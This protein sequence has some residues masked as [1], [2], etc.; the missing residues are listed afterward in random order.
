MLALLALALTATLLGERALR[1]HLLDKALQFV[2]RAFARP[3]PES[4]GEGVKQRAHANVE[5]SL[6]NLCSELHVREVSFQTVARE[7]AEARIQHNARQ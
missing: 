5:A 3:V 6:L 1:L 2:E 7:S 4:A